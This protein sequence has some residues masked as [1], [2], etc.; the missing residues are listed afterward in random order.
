MNCNTIEQYILLESTGELSA[1]QSVKLQ[2]H[3]SQCANC[4]AFAQHLAAMQSVFIANRID[5]PDAVVTSI[6]KKSTHHP[7]PFPASFRQLPRSLMKIA[8]TLVICL[9]LWLL[10]HNVHTRTQPILP[11][12]SARL[13]E[14]SDIILA[15]TDPEQWINQWDDHQTS[16]LNI[17]ELAQQILMTQGMYVEF[18]EEDET[19]NSYEERQPT[20]LLW[21]SSPSLLEEKCG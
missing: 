13:A 14:F 7:I 20:T 9:G 10:M 2:H 3:V 21:R 5:A 4:R 16:R 6:L 17:D 12:T 11:P 8:A 15:F 18:A 19:P 1:R